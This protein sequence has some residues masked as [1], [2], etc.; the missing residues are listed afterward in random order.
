MVQWKKIRQAAG[1]CRGGDS[2]AR[3]RTNDSYRPPLKRQLP[4]TCHCEE[5][6]DVAISQ[7]PTRSQESRRRNR[8]CLP[9][10]ATGAKR[11]RNDTSGGTA[12]TAVHPIDLAVLLPLRGRAG[13]APPLQTHQ[14]RPIPNF[15]FL[16]PNMINKAA[17]HHSARA[18]VERFFVEARFE[19]CRR[20]L[21]TSSFSNRRIG[22]KYPAK[23]EGAMMRCCH[24]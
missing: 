22:E 14:C 7:Y 10:I 13:H 23:A 19:K 5:R 8:N 9:E 11:P 20:A 18:F 3:R 4:P 15:S 6:S 16:I 21:C 1:C 2:R 17:P 12:L 24:K